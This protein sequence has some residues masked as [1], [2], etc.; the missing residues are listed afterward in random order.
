MWMTYP[1]S[2]ENPIPIKSANV[3]DGDRRGSAVEINPWQAANRSSPGNYH[4]A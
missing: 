3:D 2:I 1:Q 4:T